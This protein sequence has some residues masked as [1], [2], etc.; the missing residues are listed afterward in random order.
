MKNRLLSELV[1][2]LLVKR[3]SAAQIRF[4]TE[5]KLADAREKAQQANILRAV[6]APFRGAQQMRILTKHRRNGDG[7]QAL[8]F[9][10]NRNHGLP[11][12]IWLDTIIAL[13]KITLRFF[14]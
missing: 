14:L 5:G 3:L 11:E 9:S 2:D 1:H 12:K 13:H 7:E 4:A 10:D 6:P 8:R